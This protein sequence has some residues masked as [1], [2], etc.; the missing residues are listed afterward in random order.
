MTV[1]IDVSRVATDT[2]ELY[3][4]T[5]IDQ[6]HDRIPLIYKLRKMRRVITR[7]GTKIRE[8]MTFGKNTQTEHYGMGDPMGSSTED[9]RTAA[10]FGWTNTQTPIKY[11]AEDFLD[12]SGDEQVV[13]T[14]AA[15][16]SAAQED[17]LDSLSESFYATSVSG[18]AP[19]SI[20]SALLYSTTAT[21]GGILRTADN[22]ALA[23]SPVSNQWF[24]GN[25]CSDAATATLANFRIAVSAI[26]RHR[27]NRNNLLAITTP[28]IFLKY[29]SLLDAKSNLRQDGMMA[30]A[31]FT[32]FTIDG[33]EMV[34]DDNCPSGYL[35]ILDL[36]TWKWRINP[37]RNFK[38]TDFKWQGEVNDGVDEYLARIL[39]RHQL[40]CIKPRN[41]L[42]FTSMS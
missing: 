8:P 17:M 25:N 35:L 31:G 28:A 29:Q 15:E 26:M 20:F 16:V 14:I 21:Y 22:D 27:G 24:A 3:E 33:I 12:N 13:D 5:V 30:K 34:L 37:K 4:R 7:G 10:V 2:R 32:A 41:N 39:L 9:K 38:L 6:V 18:D 23:S 42:V 36:M 11:N 40:Y 19:L 1:T